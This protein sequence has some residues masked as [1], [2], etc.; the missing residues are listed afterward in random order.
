MA[1]KAI[2]PIHQFQIHD[3]VPFGDIGGMHFAL[4]NNG[5]VMIITVLIIAALLLLPTGA[6]RLVPTR[7]Q[8]V[9]EMCYEFTANMVID[10][11]GKDGLKFLPLVFALFMFLL[12]GNWIGLLPFSYTAASQVIVTSILAALVFLTVVI[13]GFKR[14][15][16]RFLKTFVPSGIPPYILWA[17]VPMEVISFLSRPVSHS[18]RLWGNMLA[19]HIVLKVFGGMAVALA[20]ALGFVGAIAA[21]GPIAMAVPLTALEFLVGALQ[22]FVFAIL[23]CVYLHDALHPGH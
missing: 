14:N 4:T 2:E 22:A 12:V 7:M 20:G 5:V 9:A 10:S 15:G 8:L 16:L 6:R 11:A 17:V 18:L 19:G 13:Y 21:I 3:V 1:E 23:T